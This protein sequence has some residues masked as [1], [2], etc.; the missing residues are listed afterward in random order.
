MQPSHFNGWGR[1]MLNVVLP[2]ELFLFLFHQGRRDGGHDNLHVQR[3]D[4]R[5]LSD[6][7][8]Q[9]EIRPSSSANN[10]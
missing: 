2:D 7:N 9:D 3:V 5:H 4:N 6:R 10:N 1:I 8:D